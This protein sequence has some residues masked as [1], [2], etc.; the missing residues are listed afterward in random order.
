MLAWPPSEAQLQ[1]RRIGTDAVLQ[2]LAS[3]VS[4]LTAAK[5]ASDLHTVLALS[6]A[7][8]RLQE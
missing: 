4:A 7:L 5:L 1:V 6:L 2:T 8:G 3:G